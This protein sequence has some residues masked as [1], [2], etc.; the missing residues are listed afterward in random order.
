MRRNGLILAACA[1]IAQ[2]AVAQSSRLDDAREALARAQQRTTAT[3]AKAAALEAQAFQAQA[4]AKRAHQEGAASRIA[5]AAAQA[6]VA[7]EQ[8]RLAEIDRARALQAEQ[9]AAQR[10]P[11]AGLLATVERMAL[12]PSALALADPPSIDEIA[13]TRAALAA[14]APAIA[15]RTAAVQAAMAE[16]RRLHVESERTSARLAEAEK[17]LAER[18]A[19]FDSAEQ[20][21]LARADNAASDADDVRR[22]LAALADDLAARRALVAALGSDAK[23]NARLAELDP[24]PLRASEPGGAIAYRLPAKGRVRIG[25]GELAPSGGR[26]RGLTIEIA[27]NAQVRAPAAGRVAYAGAFRGYGEI[28]IIDHGHGWTTLLAGLA[29]VQSQGTMVAAGAPIG[30]M[31]RAA[32]LTIELRRHARPV[33]VAA[34]AAWR[35]T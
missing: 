25:M 34:M 19:A 32:L 9:L 8:A 10:A 28:V 16:G 21:A 20:S 4:A 27:P 3:A 15:A 35:G 11:L 1:L 26:T 18:A 12:R 33:D 7:A 29:R 22:Q 17:R 14:L 24:P 30:R 6:R 2:D 31:G 5:L 13:R 23:R